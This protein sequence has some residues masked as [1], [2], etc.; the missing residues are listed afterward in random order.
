MRLVESYRDDI[1]DV[2]Q[3][4]L[5]KTVPEDKAELVLGTA[6]RVKG[7]EWDRVALGDDFGPVAIPDDQGGVQVLEEE[8]NLGYVALTRARTHLDLGSV[9]WHLKAGHA[10]LKAERAR[11]AG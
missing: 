6:H 3:R 11:G 10:L 8:V 9:G 2:A 1:P 7:M 5:T 4:L